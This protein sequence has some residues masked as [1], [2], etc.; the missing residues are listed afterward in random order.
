MQ[1]YLAKPGGQKEGPFTLEEINRDIA[2]RKYSYNDYWAWHEGLPQWMPLHSVPGITAKPGSGVPAAP[3]PAPS[4]PAPQK[5]SPIV[6]TKPSPSSA[7]ASQP[8]KVP[9][10]V[11]VATTGRVKP[12]APVRPAE[13]AAASSTTGEKADKPLS[14]SKPGPAI[15]VQGKP[16][17]PAVSERESPQPATPSKPVVVKLASKGSTPPE[18]HTPVPAKPATS[19][20]TPVVV[21]K[22]TPTT[23]PV[24][25]PQPVPSSAAPQPTADTAAKSGAEALV[26]APATSVE[27]APEIDSQPSVAGSTPA[28]APSAEPPSPSQPAADLPLEPA[29]GE[30]T[31]DTEEEPTPLKLEGPSGLPFSALEQVFVFTTGEG[32]TVFESAKVAEVVQDAV[33]EPLSDVRQRI[34]MD[35]VGHADVGVQVLIDGSVPE[36]AWRAMNAIKPAIA[37]K[38]QAGLYEVCIR[39]FSVENNDVVALFLFYDALKAGIPSDT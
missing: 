28:S 29:A 10:P 24:S 4:R 13:S 7:A 6:G 35:V 16:A 19:K 31:T 5:P 38:A 21:A 3:T 8:A 30:G 9:T 14:V 20:P 39:P 27:P 17:T 32:R 18:T 26:S 11:K 34:P 22:A 23:P 12:I 1:I 36:K 37:E 25:S 15:P 33:G 2:S